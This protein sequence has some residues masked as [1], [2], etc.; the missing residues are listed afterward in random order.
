MYIKETWED[1][2][3]MTSIIYDGIQFSIN[4]ILKEIGQFQEFSFEVIFQ[5]I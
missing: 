2:G 3:E 5:K 4:E 1:A